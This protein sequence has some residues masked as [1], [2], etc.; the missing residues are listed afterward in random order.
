MAQM[1]YQLVKAVV[2]GLQEELLAP[3]GVGL[4]VALVQTQ[5]IECSLQP[6]A[7]ALDA[8]LLAVERIGLFRKFRSLQNRHRPCQTMIIHIKKKNN[9]WIN[10]QLP[11]E[12][13]IK[14]NAAKGLRREDSRVREGGALTALS[15]KRSPTLFSDLTLETRI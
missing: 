8:N 10:Q 1:W 7:L 3:A 5:A 9:W 14:E 12:P 11:F 15:G 4:A 6:A 2:A 13:L